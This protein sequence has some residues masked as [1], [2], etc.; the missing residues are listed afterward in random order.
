M[1]KLVAFSIAHPLLCNLITIFVFIA[2]IYSFT[3]LNR[4]AFP[5]VSYDRVLVRT[6]Y[7]GSDPKSVEKLITIP[8]ERELKEVSDIKEIR[9]ISI[10]G[11]SILVVELESFVKNKDRLVNE[12]QRAVDRVPDL[13]A[14]LEDPPVVT[15]VRSKDQPVIE[16][17]LSGDLPESKLVEHAKILER[18]F[19]DLADVAAVHRNGWREKEIW[20]SARPQALAADYFSLPDFIEALAKQNVNIPGGV[21]RDSAKEYLL[22]TSG[23][24]ETAKDVET[25][26]LRANDGRHWVALK[27]VAEV[28]DTFEEE[29]LIH[30]TNGTRAI[31]LVVIKKENAD[32]IDLV[33]RV[34][35]MAAEYEARLSEGRGDLQ[36]SL[37]NDFSFYIKRRLKVLYS[38]G[39][40]GF[41]LVLI[42]LFLFLNARVAFMTALGVP[43]A[44]LATFFAMQIFGMSLNMLTMFGLITVLGMLVDDALVISENVYRHW[45]SGVPIREA[46][47]RGVEEVWKP[48]ASS[49]LT[50][51]VAFLP[52]MF[53]TGVIGKFVKFI[54]L[55][56]IIALLASLFEAYFI[57]PSHLARWVKESRFKNHHFK[58]ALERWTEKYLV[59]LKTAIKHRYRVALGAGLFFLIGVFLYFYIP[60]SLFPPRGIESFFIRAQAPVG[61][62]L[63]ETARRF[64][65]LEKLAA[66]LPKEELD[67]FVLRVGIQ[68]ND[69]HDPFTERF[70]HLGQI[71]VFLTPP[72]SRKRDAASI[73]ASLRTRDLSQTGLE[74]IEFEMLRPG[75]PIGK[76]VSIRV[77]GES[78]ENL[79]LIA[80]RL[81][82]AL[83]KLNGVKEIKSDEEAGK[84]E[85][86]LIPDPVKVAEAGLGLKEV[87][88][89]IRASFEGLV[90]TTIK[91]TDEEIAVRVRFPKQAQDDMENLKKVV[92]PN[93]RGNLVALPAI[94]AFEKSQ[95]VSAIRHFNHERVISVLA[96][97]D[98]EKITVTEVFQAM[99]PLL[100]ALQKEH[101]EISIQ[102]GGEF[103]ETTQSLAGLKQAFL[104]GALMI[105]ILLAVQF[106]SLW[107]PFLVMTS[108]PLG[109]TGVLIAFWIHGEPKSFLGMMGMVGLAGV[110]VNNAIVLVDFINEARRNG[111]GKMESIL[112]AAAVRLRPVLLTS[113][114]TVLGLVSLAYGFWGSDPFLKPMALAF[115][116][117][118]MF[119]TVL[120]LI[121]IP[122]FYAI[123]DDWR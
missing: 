119:A 97:V 4:E 41:V 9:S 61:T 64:E 36:I 28:T 31:G 34:K 88:Q 95:G 17:S 32:A 109:L 72:A 68:Q 96:N 67:D 45:E 5:N 86:L 8:L 78:L 63:E 98:E 44:I 123:A 3:Q 43:F 18:K 23:E 80:T 66:S 117:G 79:R 49:V 47:L 54:P 22:R 19:L 81:Q 101:P 51:I 53:M 115:V 99:R 92:I 62:A 11:M 77:R 65:S 73:I 114:T 108:I 111:K 100:A 12:I 59:W 56:V 83:E 105:F 42:C 33:A 50:T 82:V 118:L 71:Q 60:F 39:A 104:L 40:F 21:V 69:P 24:L 10:Q 76:P 25:V 106:N 55:M 13:P 7:P 58:G 14:D 74:K 122:C 85:L 29:S 94:A 26:V 37:V 20:V 27:D 120:T 57:L 48:V 35:K 46:C 91:K 2:G 110:V 6:A 15:E 112:E 102:F 84:E 107:Q 38:N 121:I 116:W 1:K 30:R 87:G 52:L 90:A 70:S 16:V 113:V 93:A 103:E 75:P 89:A